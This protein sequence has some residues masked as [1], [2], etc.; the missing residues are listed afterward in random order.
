MNIIRH[1]LG[2]KQVGTIKCLISLYLIITLYSCTEKVE[3]PNAYS[4]R[5][6]NH[7]FEPIDSVLFGKHYLGKIKTKDTSK[8]IHL[9]P[10]GKYSFSCKTKSGLKIS[11]Q[12]N[13]LGLKKDLDIVLNNK[14]II[15]IK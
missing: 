10:R 7:Y 4:V 3:L 6:H 11:T 14:G 5:V 12:V 8:Y 9:V 1:C 13:I 15:G 2:I